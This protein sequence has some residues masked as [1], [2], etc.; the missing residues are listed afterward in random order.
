MFRVSGFNEG[1]E[2][3]FEFIQGLFRVIWDLLLV[4]LR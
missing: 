2:V 1:I 4:Y 3:C